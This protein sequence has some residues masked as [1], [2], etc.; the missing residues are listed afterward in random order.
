MRENCWIHSANLPIVASEPGNS[1]ILNV[2]PLLP[3]EKDNITVKRELLF[4]LL[5]N[6]VR[7]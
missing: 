2:K 7:H 5:S 1:P 6:F 4:D 3:V